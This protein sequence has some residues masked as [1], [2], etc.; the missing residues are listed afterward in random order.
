[1]SNKSSLLFPANSSQSNTIKNKTPVQEYDN[2][3][4]KNPVE[5]LYLRTE[6]NDDYDD[7]E[8]DDDKIK[9]EFSNDDYEN[10]L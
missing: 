7:D 2:N 3:Y 4:Q 5:A 8:E 6:D 10:C 1:M 9:I